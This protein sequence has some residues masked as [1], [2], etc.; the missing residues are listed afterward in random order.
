MIENRSFEA[1]EGYGVPGGLYMVDDFG[2]GWSS[3]DGGCDKSPRMQFVSGTPLAS[4]NPHYLR[5]TAYEAGQ[6]FKNK[7]YDGICIRKDAKYKVSF[8]ARCVDYSGENIN[9]FV[10]KD[11]KIYCEASVEAVKPLPYYPF[12][13][14][15]MEFKSGDDKMDEKLAEIRA[16]DSSKLIPRN[17]WQKYEVEL[18]AMAD[19][20]GASF[21]ITLDKEGVVE[22][23]LI[24][25]IPEDAVEGI[26]R[27]DL[28]EAL[29]SITPGF[30]R[31]PG[32]CIIEGISLPK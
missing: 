11:G 10:E 15:T 26:F 24:S 28:F 31:F 27:K 30:I 17:A 16:M 3:Y 7:A 20:R 29:K 32:G 14:L 25:M 4:E 1:K 22:F 9:I 19:V 23:D 21:V 12:Q 8:Y 6:G 5:F 13:D 18:T 2:Y